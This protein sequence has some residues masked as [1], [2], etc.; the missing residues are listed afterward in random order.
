MLDAVVFSQGDNQNIIVLASR[1]D[2]GTPTALVSD[3]KS[4]QIAVIPE[5]VGGASEQIT[6]F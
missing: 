1:G 5:K 6:I 4:S 2:I 3:T